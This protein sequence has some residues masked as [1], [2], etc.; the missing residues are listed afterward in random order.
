MTVTNTIIAYSKNTDQSGHDAYKTMTNCGCKNYLLLF[1]L[2][3]YSKH[4]DHFRIFLMREKEKEV[5]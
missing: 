1:R 3:R 5:F 2:L 4:I